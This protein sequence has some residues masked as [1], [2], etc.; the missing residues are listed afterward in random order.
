MT[1]GPVC[2]LLA[3]LGVL[4][5]SWRRHVGADMENSLVSWRPAVWVHP[6]AHSEPPHQWLAHHAILSLRAR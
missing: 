2:T 3:L 1:T 5:L 4:R 6:A